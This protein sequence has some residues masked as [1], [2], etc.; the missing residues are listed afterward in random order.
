MFQSE[1]SGLILASGSHT[2][3]SLLEK[4]GLSF[5]IDPPSIDEAS[6]RAVFEMEE[7]DPADIA[8]VLAEAKAQHISK[9][10]GDQIVIG[11]DQVLALGDEI[12]SKPANKDEAYASLFKLRGKT[13]RLISSIVIVKN[14]AV[15]W[16]YSDTATL[17]MRQFSPEFLGEYLAHSG[18]AIYKSPGSYQIEQFGI[19][20]FEEI[21]GDYFTILGFPLLP[22]LDFLRREN[23]IRS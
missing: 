23:L 20:L 7:T 5:E 16:R 17:T 13:H 3:A 9:S 4:T 8:E 14:S 2:R 18:D 1:N 21:K 12:I 15:L 6:I 10:R 22:L 11:S 19:H